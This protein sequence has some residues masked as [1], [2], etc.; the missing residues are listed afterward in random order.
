MLLPEKPIGVRVVMRNFL[1]EI[2]GQSFLI[3]SEREFSVVY[4]T[5]GFVEFRCRQ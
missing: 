1:L 2:C 3:G 5:Q 4:A